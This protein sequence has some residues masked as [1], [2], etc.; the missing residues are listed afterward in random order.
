MIYSADV[1]TF[2]ADLHVIIYSVFFINKAFYI[3]PDIDYQA[4]NIEKKYFSSTSHALASFK[5]L[6]G[7]DNWI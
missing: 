5:I 3:F 4:L 1:K 7:G 2:D 6:L